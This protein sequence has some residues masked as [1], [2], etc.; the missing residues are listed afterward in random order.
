[1]NLF[2]A[3]QHSTPDKVRSKQ[4]FKNPEQRKGFTNIIIN[5]FTS[6]A[7]LANTKKPAKPS[8]K[9]SPATQDDSN[10]FASSH[11]APIPLR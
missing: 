9:L 11:K 1:M 4:F 7:R 3:N 8:I 10:R 5:R 6:G 2:S